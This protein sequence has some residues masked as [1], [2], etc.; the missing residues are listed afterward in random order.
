[1]NQQ[2][3]VDDSLIRSTFKD[4]EALVKTIRKAML[5]QKLNAVDL[6]NLLSLMPN[7]DLQR[8]LR[9]YLCPELNEDTPIGVQGDFF[10]S[11]PIKDIQ[12]ENAVWHIRGVSLWREYMKQQLDAIFSGNAQKKQ[13]LVFADLE[14]T[15]GLSDVE[16]FVNH[17]AR[18]HIAKQIDLTLLK[19]IAKANEKEKTPEEL[20]K[21]REQNSSK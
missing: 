13:K 21:E 14:A 15:E 8:I 10:M 20:E 3:Q 7:K 1:M 5:Q 6:A 9:D 11:I 18:T 19:L 2:T 4:N 12:P 17:F 16:V